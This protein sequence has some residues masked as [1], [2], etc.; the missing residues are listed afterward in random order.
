M[1]PLLS[2]LAG[3]LL[4]LLPAA[5]TPAAE[6]SEPEPDRVTL[7]EGRVLEGR[8]VFEDYRRLVLRIKSRTSEIAKE[9]ID[10]VNAVIRVLPNALNQIAS[11]D[12]AR[13]DD[14]L[15]L[16][17][18]LEM[19]NLPYEA[20]LV[21]WSV[22]AHHPQHAATH[23]ALGHRERG[24]TW[25]VRHEGR[26]RPIEDLVGTPL[27]WK[28]AWRFRTTHW[29][30]RTNL[31]LADA[32]E[33]A[34]ELERLYRGFYATFA[35][36]MVLHD[37]T[38]P[39]E[40]WVHADDTSYPEFVGGRAGYFSRE[41]KR[42]YVNATRGRPRGKL[43]HEATHALFFFIAEDKRT[44]AGRFPGWLNEGLAEY[45]E[46]SAVGPRGRLEIEAGIPNRR[47]FR[48]HAQSDKPYRLNRVL[49]LQTGDFH[50]STKEDLKY[51]QSY[52]LVHFCLHAEGGR[53]RDGFFA[54]LRG[55]FEGK[56]SSTHF[57]RTIGGRESDLEE[58]WHRYAK[59]E[60]Q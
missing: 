38:T 18:Q 55:V 58:A 35:E 57:K 10:S 21:R 1:L 43:V 11:L 15:A 5:S 27:D 6:V 29:S 40:A 44:S 25:V 31:P 20:H 41:E 17:E 60:A 48:V 49:N 45:M 46:A 52:T 12:S 9:E 7:K 33:T 53:Y 56:I 24:E 47:H 8:V 16:A 32:I 28:L 34:F 37:L 59:A 39:L 42:L 30:L 14:A 51:A 19:V 3:A 4:A 50:A 26:W 22:L 2:P 36:G 13:P 23:E 54:F